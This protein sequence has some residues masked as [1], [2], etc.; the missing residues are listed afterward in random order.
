MIFLTG[1]LT[2]FR[3]YSDGQGE[4]KVEVLVERADFPS[5]KKVELTEAVD[6]EQPVEADEEDLPF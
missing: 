2:S 5:E 1:R 6:D 4:T 3:D